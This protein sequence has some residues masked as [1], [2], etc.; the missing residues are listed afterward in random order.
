MRK[1]SSSYGMSSWLSAKRSVADKQAAQIAYGVREKEIN[2][3]TNIPLDD[4]KNI[5]KFK[6]I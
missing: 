2:V 3:Q 1:T 5:A 4:P 6:N